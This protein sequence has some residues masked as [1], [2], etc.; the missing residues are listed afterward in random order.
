MVDDVELARWIAAKLEEGGSQA[1][2]IAA[3][4]KEGSS[5]DN[6]TRGDRP[7]SKSSTVPQD[8]GGRPEKGPWNSWIDR[9][10]LRASNEGRPE[11][12]EEACRWLQ[13][14]AEADG[15]R[16]SKTAAQNHLRGAIPITFE[17][18]SG[19]GNST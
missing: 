12:K 16:V 10:V 14:I 5:E 8:K 13:E 3:M 11:S 17:A 6:V 4:L 18:C 1:Q 19:S 7:P 15:Y 2:W 9:W